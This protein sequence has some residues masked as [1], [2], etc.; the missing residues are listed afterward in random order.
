MYS[1]SLNSVLLTYFIPSSLINNS[2][3]CSCFVFQDLAVIRG[4]IRQACMCQQW[5]GVC[6]YQT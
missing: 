2:D 3:Q 4:E 1:Y 5:L 6:C